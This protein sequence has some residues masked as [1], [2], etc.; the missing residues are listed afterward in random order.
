M[1]I[2]SGS[3]QRCQ[4]VQISLGSGLILL[5]RKDQGDIDIDAFTDQPGN[6]RDALRRGRHL[7]HQIRA[8]QRCEEPSSFIQSAG[9]VVGQLRA[10][11]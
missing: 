5:Q 4:A 7:D 1:Q 2:A 9:G 3:G 6:R 11:L 10:D 8:I